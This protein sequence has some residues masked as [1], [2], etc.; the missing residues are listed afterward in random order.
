MSSTW[1]GDND[2][3]DSVLPPRT[4]TG[5]NAD[6]IKTIVEWKRNSSGKRVKVTKKINLTRSLR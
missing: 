1:G 2:D 4:E 3:D 6:G 5:P